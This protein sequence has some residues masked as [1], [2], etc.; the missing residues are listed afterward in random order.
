M[1]REDADQQGYRPSGF[2][3]Q[4]V[5]YLP[6]LSVEKGHCS[7]VGHATPQLRPIEKESEKQTHL[8]ALG[9]KST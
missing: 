2:C 4:K 6:E 8:S 5:A 9:E 3:F 1:K 7:R